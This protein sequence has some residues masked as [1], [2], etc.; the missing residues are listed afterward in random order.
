MIGEAKDLCMV[1][2][3]ASRRQ[4][5]ANAAM[6]LVGL[7]TAP[8]LRSKTQQPDMKQT[9]SSAA[10]QTR[11][12]LHQ[13]IELK[14][15]PQ[16]V[17]EVLL[18]SKQFAAFTGM[19]AEIDPK[20]GGALSMFG[21]MIV[22]RNVELIPNQR[23]VQ[24]WRSAGWDA[25]VYSIVKFELKPG[26]AGTIVVLDHSGFPQGSFDHLDPGWYMRYWD[27]LTKYLGQVK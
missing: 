9:P 22:G 3:A 12:S 11:T 20:A 2:K 10:N 16:R 15:T 25:G 26:G 6:A 21:A 18:D 5:I 24:A 1:G 17:Y 23:I 8:Q 4:L 7:A 13:E 19:P 27:P 14:A